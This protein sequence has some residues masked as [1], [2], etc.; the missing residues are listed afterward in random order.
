MS[1]TNSRRP[2]RKPR[3][4]IA[5]CQPFLAALLRSKP[6]VAD[7]QRFAPG[8]PAEAFEPQADVPVARVGLPYQLARAPLKIG[9]E[10]ALLPFV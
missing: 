8:V 9:S 5:P 2:T 6:T 7:L 3:A 10:S 4:E 1:R